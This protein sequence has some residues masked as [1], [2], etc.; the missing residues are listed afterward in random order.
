VISKKDDLILVGAISVAKGLKGEVL[1]KYFAQNPSVFKNYSYIFIGP[2]RA[3]YSIDRCT[4]QK[5]NISVTFNEINDRTE[6]EKLKGQEIFIEKTQLKDLNEDEWYHQDLIGLKVETL[7]GKKLGIIKAI[8]NFGA[9]DI[10]EIKLT[11]NKIEMIP[12]NK[13]FVLDI[14]LNDK[15]IISDMDF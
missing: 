2:L 6:A 7:E 15:V 9:G 12:F 3:K 4:S 13:D 10:L 11:N 14:I 1:I 8:Y 5:E